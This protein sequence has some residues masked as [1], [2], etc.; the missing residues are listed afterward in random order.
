MFSLITDPEKVSPVEAARISVSA[1]D[2][3]ELLRNWLSE[4]NYR[5]VAEQRVFGSFA[6]SELTEVRAEGEARGERLDPARHDVFGEVKAVTFH[7]LKVARE[8][9][10]WVAR[11]IFDV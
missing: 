2:R 8:G 3:D 9:G 4:L 11:V 6:V 10:Q 7:G 5:H 1:N